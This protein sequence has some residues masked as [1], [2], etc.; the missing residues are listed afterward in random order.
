MIIVK[1]MGGLGNQMFQYAAAKALAERNGVPLKIDLSFLNDRS[2]KENFTF[3]EFEL[4]CF[5]IPIE[6]ATKEELSVFKCKN[7]FFANVLDLIGISTPIVYFEKSLNYDKSFMQLPKETLLIGYFQ[8]EKYFIQI[9]HHILEN[10]KWISPASDINFS[11]INS[12]ESTNSVSIHIRRGD[13]VNNEVI[14]S[15]HGSCDID[16][17]K[18]AISYINLYIENPTF[19]IFSDDIS[20][21][22]KVFGMMSSVIF[23]SHNV[24]KESFW[25]MRL[26]SYCKNNI[27]AN[28]SFSWWGAWLNPNKTKIIIAPKIWYNSD[29][30]ELQTKTLIPS[31][32][33]RI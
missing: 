21:A 25:D 8:S 27:I 32:W 13:F 2:E 9:R 17:Y 33:T 20:W 16:Y 15:I 31:G 12:I 4:A 6:I 5:D 18:R 26:M 7:R 30:L 19:F 24:G 3:R 22:K 28:S 14:N 29:N 10:F 11:L 23:I 1:L